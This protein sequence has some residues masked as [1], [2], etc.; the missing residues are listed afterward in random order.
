MIYYASYPTIHQS[1]IRAVIEKK[2]VW[3]GNM[4]ATR[5]HEMV[6]CVCEFARALT[7]CHQSLSKMSKWSIK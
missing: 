2:K 1:G 5:G 4:T 7:F 6:V 3:Y